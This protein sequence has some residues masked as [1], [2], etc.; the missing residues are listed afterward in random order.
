MRCFRKDKA[1]T[2]DKMIAIEWKI[3]EFI[4]IEAGWAMKKQ[5]EYDLSGRNIR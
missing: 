1:S 5:M 4:T 3:I 2:D